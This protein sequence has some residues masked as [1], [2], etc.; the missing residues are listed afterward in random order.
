MQRFLKHVTNDLGKIEKADYFKIRNFCLAKDTIQRFFLKIHR[1]KVIAI[2]IIHNR[3]T[4]RICKEAPQT[5]CKKT[6]QL[7]NEPNT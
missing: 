3:F 4:S 7:K 1:V 2:F 6:A 5:K